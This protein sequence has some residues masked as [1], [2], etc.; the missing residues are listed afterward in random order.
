MD[1]EGHLI[2]A[3]ANN[4]RLQVLRLEDG[5]HVRSIGS[6][7]SGP[8]QFKEPCGVVLICAISTA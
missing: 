1:G 4:H 3:D 7:G 8:G 2:V 5:S 6:E